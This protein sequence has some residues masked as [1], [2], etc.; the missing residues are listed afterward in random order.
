MLKERGK[1]VGQAL[2]RRTITD[3]KTKKGFTI[4]IHAQCHAQSFYETLG[5]KKFGDE[6][7]EAGISHL[8]MEYLNSPCVTENAP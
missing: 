4:A 8:Y 3:A 7:E 1:G 2:I 6:F 5:F